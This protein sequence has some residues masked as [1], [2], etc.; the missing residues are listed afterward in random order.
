MNAQQRITVAGFKLAWWAGAHFSVATMRR[1]FSLFAHLLFVIGG[2]SRKRAQFNLARILG[3]S[4]SDSRAVASARNMYQSYFR[5]WAEMFCLP[6]MS[7]PELRALG[8]FVNA[9][10]VHTVLRQGRGVLVAATH[11]GNWD[12]AGAL[13]ADEFGSVTS[14]A[15]RLEPV[16]LF[17][18]FVAARTH[19]HVE[20]LPHRGGERRPSDV[21]AERLNGGKVVALATDRDMSRRGIPATLAGHSI[22]I[23]AGPVKLTQE[24]GA[25]LIPAAVYFDGEVSVME[26]FPEIST[27]GR[28]ETDVAQDL[29]DVFELL[30]K[31]HP[32]NWHML[33]QVWLDHPSEWGGRRA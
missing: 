27:A 33:Q 11:S 5:Y 4:P 24:T 13:A 17:D 18:A 31:R 12:L 20:I 6:S 3:V 21:L 1:I 23:P 14:V 16:E 10:Y 15:E 7:Q 22:K 19:L 8:R 25:A 28:S 2:T 32:E 26:F 29:V 30:I 9:D